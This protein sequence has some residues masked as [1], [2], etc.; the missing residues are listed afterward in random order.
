MIENTLK[1]EDL[2]FLEELDRLSQFKDPIQNKK[3]REAEFYYYEVENN[4]IVT[5]NLDDARI[6]NLPESIGN[7]VALRTLSLKGNMDIHLPESIKNL[8]SLKTLILSYNRLKT[9]PEIITQLTNL[10]NL[11]L[12]EN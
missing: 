8:K 10:E 2:A 5:L 6:T 12:K 3:E 7:L 4:E 1:K 9:F 11:D